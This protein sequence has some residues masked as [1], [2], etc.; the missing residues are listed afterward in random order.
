MLRESLV[1]I[2]SK[3]VPAGIA[4][5]TGMVLTWLLQ[6]EEYGVYGLGFAMIVL[7]SAIFFDWHAMSFMRFYQSNAANPTFMP[8]ILQSFLLLCI[9][10]LVLAGLAY[11]SGMLSADYRRLLWICVPGCWCYAWFEL[12]A[13]MEVARFK[14][15]HYFWMNL[16]R[17]SAIL[18]LGIVLA[19]TTRSALAVLAG[20]FL[21]MLGAALIY[22]GHGFSLSPQR[23]DRAVVRRLW[24]F[25]WPVGI[26][27]ILM[28]TSFAMDRFLLDHFADKASVGFYTV[29][30]ALT[31][32]TISTIGAGIDSAI[33][34][35]AVKVADSNDREALRLQLS[36]SCALLLTVLLPATVGVA[37]LAPSLARLCVAP[38][39]VEP[40]SGLIAWMAIGAFVLNF[41]ANYVDHGFHFGHTTSRL[42]IVIATIV[43]TNL[44]ADLILIP[45]YGALGAAQ[46]GIIAG[47]V[48]LIHGTLAART[49]VVLPF[50]LS[51]IGKI[52][53]ATLAM[54]AF[55]WPFR[56]A[57][58]TAMMHFDKPWSILAGV[59]VLMLQ[60]G[61]GVAVFALCA[62]ALNIM[63]LRKVAA[64]R[65]AVLK[66]R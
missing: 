14:P 25:G 49:L 64:A 42:T 52:L 6:P 56:G 37:M 38:A 10:S 28:A 3:A 46:A 36:R 53:A 34:S 39:Y 13:R 7:V 57:T 62:L 1:Y 32:T 45:R 18:A 12:S 60:A 20:N 59:A 23:F 63:N 29:A 54:G 11:A 15:G 27:Q 17:N 21:A 48:G 55:L 61:G 5:A 8:T 65:L 9:S 40:V 24:V 30:Y 51:E 43:V 33:Y 44:V 19:W 47:T 66:T 50:P 41:R 35:R 22:R 31:R 58:E 16:V 2:L 4:F 26:V